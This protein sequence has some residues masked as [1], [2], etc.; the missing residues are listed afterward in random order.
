MTKKVLIS[1]NNSTCPRR[2]TKKNKQLTE[3]LNSRWSDSNAV[4]Q[5]PVG[6]LLAAWLE[7]QLQQ[8]DNNK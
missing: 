4:P 6:F 7:V 2:T 8:Y 1:Q 3:G 5:S